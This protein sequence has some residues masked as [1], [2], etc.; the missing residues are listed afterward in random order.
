M[1]PI[2]RSVEHI[3]NLI[4]S[5]F[6]QGSFAKFMDSPYYSELEL[7]GGAMMVSFLKYFL[8][9]AMH[10]LHSSLQNFLPWSSLFVV[11]KAQKSHGVEI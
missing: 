11:G 9:Q 1:V 10:P 7:C 4:S 8:W 2:L 5:V 6:V 3:R